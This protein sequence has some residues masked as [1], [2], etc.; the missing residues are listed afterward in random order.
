MHATKY[1]KHS[2]FK[3]YETFMGLISLI[4]IYPKKENLEQ[5]DSK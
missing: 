5:S 3:F 4:F 1:L 2:L